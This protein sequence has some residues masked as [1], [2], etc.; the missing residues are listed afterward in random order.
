MILRTLSWSPCFVEITRIWEV[1][2]GSFYHSS[3]RG[4]DGY[5]P[6]DSKRVCFSSGVS[7]KW[8][9]RETNEQTTGLK[10]RSKTVPI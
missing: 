3:M 9:L 4:K 6:G 7:I 5:T 1:F 8:A 10:R 2:F